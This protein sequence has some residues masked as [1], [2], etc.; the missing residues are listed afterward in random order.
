MVTASDHDNQLTD[1][2]WGVEHSR[3]DLQPEKEFEE[4]EQEYSG[5]SNDSSDE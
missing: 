3:V 4:L 2:T 5:S 1:E